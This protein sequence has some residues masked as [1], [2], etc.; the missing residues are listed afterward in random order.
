MKTFKHIIFTRFDVHSA[1]ALDENWFQYRLG[2]FKKYTLESLLYQDTKD[3]ALWIRYCPDFFEQ[4]KEFNTWLKATMPFPVFFTTFENGEDHNTEELNDYVKDVDFV[5]ETRVDSDDM[6]SNDA[7]TIIQSQELDENQAYTFINGYLYRESTNRLYL[8]SGTSAPFYTMTYPM[9]V[10]IDTKKKKAYFP[11]L[12]D[13]SKH[14]DCK[15]LPEGKYLVIVHDKNSTGYSEAWVKKAGM[16][17]SAMNNVQESSTVI[18]NR[19]QI[20]NSFKIWTK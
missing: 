15:I 6:Y 8:Y 13:P 17:S 11:F 10:F 4:A 18:R 14:P 1:S 2:I 5:V 12:P 7:F 3:F 16:Q 19:D 20:L 9:N